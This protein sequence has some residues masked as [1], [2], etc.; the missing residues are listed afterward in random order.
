MAARFSLRQLEYMVAVGEAGSVLAASEKVNVSS[1]SISAAISQLEAELG[2]QLFVRQHAQ[3]LS[4]TSGGQRFFNEAKRILHS[5]A[6]LGDLANDIV[7]MVRGP[8]SVGCLVT[9]A[10]FVGAAFRRSFKEEY[11]NIEVSMREGNQ[12]ELLTMLARAEIDIA[13][14][15]DLDIPASYDFKGLINLPPQ[16]ILAADNPLA[17]KG[18]I[19]I[20]DLVDEPMVLL[21]L[22][23]SSNYF[24]SLFHERGLR[25]YVAERASNLSS[26]R[27]LVANGFGYGLLNISTKTNLAPD[28]KKL[29]FRQLVGKHRPMVFGVARMKSNYSS[30]IVTAF[31]DHVRRRVAKSGLPGMS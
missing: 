5:V 8:I 31:A 23:L 17:N 26:L 29:V 21:D 19:A 27:S 2:V 3:G 14:A 9:L 30:R 7:D 12:A 20:E 4:L 18:D 6:L 28:G 15:Y 1:S 25:P 24:L 13:I 10:P 11:P 16:L 22:P